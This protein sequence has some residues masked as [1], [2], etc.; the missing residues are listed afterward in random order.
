VLAGANGAG[1]SS[2]G[3]ELLLAAGGSFFNPDAHARRLRHQLR[4]LDTEAANA[5]AW[6]WGRAGLERAIAAR[7]NYAFETTLGGHTIAGLLG[8]AGQAGLAVRVWFVGLAHPDMNVARVRA[9]VAN[10]GH[11]IPEQD[12]RRR[13]DAGRSNLVR[14]LPVLD[15]LRVYDN[16]E[17]GDPALGHSP[18]PR[19]VLHVVRQGIVGPA[20]LAA[21]PKWAKGI[22]VA[23]LKLAADGW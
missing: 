6:N 16:S 5:V 13:Y 20:N 18:H 7:G 11:D 2:V 9:R 14:L 1:K 10:G 23:A 8:R 12:I 21:T 19:L 17:D 15:E 3:G 4:E 22:V